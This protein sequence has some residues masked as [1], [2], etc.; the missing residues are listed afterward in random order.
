M[1]ERKIE[2]CIELILWMFEKPFCLWHLI[3]DTFVI[4]WTIVVNNTLWGQMFKTIKLFFIAQPLSNAGCVALQTTH[5]LLL[6][7]NTSASCLTARF[8][9]MKGL[10]SVF[11]KAQ[12]YT[13]TLLT[14]RI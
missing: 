9:N 1:Y 10:S 3:P 8:N 7:H 5:E 6:D 11:L 14:N 2:S 12:S 4:L 13:F